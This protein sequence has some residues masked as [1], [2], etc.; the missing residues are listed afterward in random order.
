MRRKRQ[1]LSSTELDVVY[2]I[3]RR[4]CKPACLL[5]HSSLAWLHAT[6]S[7]ADSETSMLQWNPYLTFDGTCEAAF[8]FYERALGG[9]LV[10]LIPFGDTPHAE[11]IPAE[12]RKK[13]MHSRLVV[14]NQILMGSDGRPGEP[15]EGI[16][17]CSIALQVS[18]P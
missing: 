17:G 8:K 1:R 11:H 13:I 15:Y 18:T 16:K 5:I 2:E 4:Q 12:A 14:G 6:P 3:P 9:K 10:A 7:P